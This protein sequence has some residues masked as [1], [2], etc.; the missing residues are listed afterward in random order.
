M[1]KSN[2][3]NLMKVLVTEKRF[4]S[5]KIDKV[6]ASDIFNVVKNYM[7]IEREDLKTQLVLDDDGCYVFRCKVKA[8]RVKVFGVV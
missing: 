7:E 6:M 1:K 2:I 8:K 3:N 4:D 5:Q